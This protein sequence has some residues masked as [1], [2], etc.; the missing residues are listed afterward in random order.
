MLKAYDKIVGGLEKRFKD[1]IEKLL[2]AQAKRIVDTYLKITTEKK[3]DEVSEEDAEKIAT[4]IT[5]KIF[6]DEDTQVMM[7]ALLPLYINS[8][9]LGNEFFNLLHYSNVEEGSVYSVI[10]DRYLKW[11]NEYG[12]KRIVMIDRTT[13]QIT[14]EIIKEGLLNGDSNNVIV[15]SLLDQIEQYSRKRAIRIAETEIHNTFMYANNLTANQSGFKYKKWISS[16]DASVRPS[17]KEL[18]GKV[19]DINKDFKEGLAYPGDSRAPARETVRCRCI[20]RY[21]LKKE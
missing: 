2:L 20:V 18:D 11:L 14:K 3:E 8:G 12:C 1:K 6:K 9:Q 17:H 21:L 5:D 10:E 4:E 13:K 19:V 16:R 15:K 7:E